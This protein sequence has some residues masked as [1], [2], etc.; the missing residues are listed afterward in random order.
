MDTAG[1]N[2]VGIRLRHGNLP[3]GG[4]REM[5][6]LFVNSSARFDS[7]RREPGRFSLCHHYTIRNVHIAITNCKQTENNSEK[8]SRK[9]KQNGNKT[10]T[11]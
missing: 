6:P 9:G 10:K 3:F 5:P 11:N 7:A 2:S 4:R 1:Q 8:H